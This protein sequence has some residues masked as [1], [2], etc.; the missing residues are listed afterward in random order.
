MAIVVL[1]ISSQ[2]CARLSHSK[3]W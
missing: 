3:Y 2:S 1:P